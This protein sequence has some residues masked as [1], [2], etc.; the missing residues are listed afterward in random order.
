MKAIIALCALLAC[1]PAEAQ[2]IY[3]WVD[4][5]GRVQYTEKPPP[6]VKAKPLADRIN[7]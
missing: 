6:G 4:D 5:N 1:T 3:R 7:S 2:P